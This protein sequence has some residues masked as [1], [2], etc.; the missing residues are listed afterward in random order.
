MKI[1]LIKVA[2]RIIINI[3][4]DHDYDSDEYTGLNISVFITES[5]RDHII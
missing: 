2:F 5:T 1:N 4:S 3:I